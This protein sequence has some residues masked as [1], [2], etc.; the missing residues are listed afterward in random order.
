MCEH[1][2]LTSLTASHIGTDNEENTLMENKLLPS[3]TQSNPNTAPLYIPLP[4]HC[5]HRSLGTEIFFVI[6]MRI[7]QYTNAPKSRYLPMHGNT[8]VPL[9]IT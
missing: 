7:L 4:S 2:T 8:K 6:S 9:S 1:T 5:A 3:N